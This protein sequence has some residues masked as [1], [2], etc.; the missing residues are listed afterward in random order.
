MESGET[1]M[2][3][4][5]GR[6][7]GRMMDRMMGGIA[8]TGL[9]R[10]MDDDMS[11]HG[12][13]WR[14]LLGC[15]TVL[16]SAIAWWMDA[17][18]VLLQPALSDAVPIALAAVQVAVLV[19]FVWL[20]MPACVLCVGEYVIAAF[21][22][23]SQ[24]DMLA[25]G[26]MTCVGY[27]SYRLRTWAALCCLLL[28]WVGQGVPVVIWREPVERLGAVF[29]INAA[30]FMVGTMFA[31]RG[32]I[33]RE[34]R[35][36]DKLHA[37]GALHDAVTGELSAIALLS[38][39]AGESDF[40]DDPGDVHGS[41]SGAASGDG[42]R[43]LMRN[44][45]GLS[46]AAL[47]NTHEVIRLLSETEDVESNAADIVRYCESQKQWLRN[48]GFHGTIRV[49]AD[50]CVLS[51]SLARVI[52]QCIKELCANIARHADMKTPYRLVL[53]CGNDGIVI[54][55]SNGVIVSDA[56]GD[57]EEGADEFRRSLQSGFGL[58]LLEERITGF[59]GAMSRTFRHGTWH[60]R[61]RL[62]R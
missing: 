4:T 44:I 27:L 31:Y 18:A 26:V 54:E 42:G 51:P 61:I 11:G 29:L 1:P 49:E 55:Q 8:G 14:M 38:Q 9:L 34:R 20:P 12:V 7:L 33:S 35:L 19:L 17:D 32:R 58:A 43:A 46:L 40:G 10:P 36:T 56:G 57:A 60:I 50:R 21:V 37:A 28:I 25:L 39:S 22:P 24:P 45:N 52:R 47:D 6:T 2:S 16:A 48:L 5:M 59:G 13:R 62:P 53:Q 15:L 41:A 30:A 23:G 3:G